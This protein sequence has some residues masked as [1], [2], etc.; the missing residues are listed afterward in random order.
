MLVLKATQKSALAILVA[1]AKGN[2]AA[3]EGAPVWSS[4]DPALVSVEPAADGL[5]AVIKAVGPV[6]STPVQINVSADA[7]LGEGVRTITGLLEV[8]VI[9]AD[10]A[11]IAIPP[12]APEE[13]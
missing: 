5:G 8:T 11:A 3:V 12:T 7:D 6:T 4:S 1:D 2:P 9:A 10:A 13:Q